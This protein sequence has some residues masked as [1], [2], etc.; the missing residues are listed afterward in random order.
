MKIQ[1]ALDRLTKQQC[2]SILE[3]TADHIDWIEI[4]TGVIKEY[5]MGMFGKLARPTRIK[6]LL[7]T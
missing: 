3:E 6:Q 1:L 7:P 4:G 5:G 2:F